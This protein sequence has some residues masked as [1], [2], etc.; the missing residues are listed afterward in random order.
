METD[1]PL[2]KPE[3]GQMPYIAI[4]FVSLSVLVFVGLVIMT[5]CGLFDIAGWFPTD[6][7]FGGERYVGS[8]VLTHVVM[9]N[10]T[11]VLLV[12]WP[13][14]TVA[15]IVAEKQDRERHVAA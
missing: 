3:D 11:R 12:L 14:L 7:T 8:E 10:V 6:L 1:I 13:I 4:P 9:R 15:M 5:I 2:E